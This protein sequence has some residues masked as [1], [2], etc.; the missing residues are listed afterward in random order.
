MQEKSQKQIA[1]LSHDKLNVVSESLVDR[2]ED[3]FDYFSIE[4]N[5]GK[6]MYYGVCPIHNG[7]NSSAFNM[8]YDGAMYRGNWRCRTHLCEN[9]F[10][11]TPIGFIRGLLSR[12]DYS[13]TQKGDKL[14]T[15]KDT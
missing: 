10:K 13:W 12:F 9:T 4:W 8:Y 3:V 15:F 1:R 7:D 6:K 2:I 14:A 11:K 5:K